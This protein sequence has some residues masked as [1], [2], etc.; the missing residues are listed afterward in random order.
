MAGWVVYGFAGNAGDLELN[1]L[2][3]TF[4][5]VFFRPGDGSPNATNVVLGAVLLGVVV[6]R[7][8]IC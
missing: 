7:F 1:F 6:I 3:S 8:A 4:V 5:T 2:F